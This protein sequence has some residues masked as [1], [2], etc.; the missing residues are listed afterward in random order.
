MELRQYLWMELEEQ[1]L[2]FLL[3]WM[4]TCVVYTGRTCV[5]AREAYSGMYVCA[6]RYSRIVLYNTIAIH[7]VILD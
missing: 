4:S 2:V 1:F 5:H 6:C 3:Q 7:R